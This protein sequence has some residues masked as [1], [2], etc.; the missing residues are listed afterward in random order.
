LQLIHVQTDYRRGNPPPSHR[1]Q[2]RQIHANAHMSKRIRFRALFDATIV[3]MVF[4]GVGAVAGRLLALVVLGAAISAG[5]AAIW[6]LRWWR[7]REDLE[8]EG[9]RW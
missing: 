4:V 3:L 1:G 7:N 2:S 8:G 6:L 5:V 9:Y